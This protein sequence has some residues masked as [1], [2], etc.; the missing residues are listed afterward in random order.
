T[1]SSRKEDHAMTAR[2]PRDDQ[3]PPRRTVL[4]L[5]GAPTLAVGAAALAA[6]RAAHAGTSAATVGPVPPGLRPGGQLDQLVRQQAAQDQFSGSFLLAYRGRPV[7][8]RSYGMAVKNLSIPNTQD[9]LFALASVTKTMTA[10][11]VMQLVQQGKLSLWETL[12][13][14]LP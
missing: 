11:A 2:S 13:T 6:P 1:P 8:A 10:T 3:R 9:T 12:G 14:Y 4:G 5:L 7:L